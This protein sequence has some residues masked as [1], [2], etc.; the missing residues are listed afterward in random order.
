M[1]ATYECACDMVGRGIIG[2]RKREGGGGLCDCLFHDHTLIRTQKKKYC[3]WD[4]AT[5]HASPTCGPTWPGVSHNTTDKK[6][7]DRQRSLKKGS[8]AGRVT[9]SS[10]FRSSTMLDCECVVRT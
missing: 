1:V 2:R 7:I 6:K 3:P 5:G 4:L 8:G 10:F 9:L